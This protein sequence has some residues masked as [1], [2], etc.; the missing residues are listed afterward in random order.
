MPPE[1][2]HAT[3]PFEE[4]RRSLAIS[5]LPREAIVSIAIFLCLWQ[6]M[7][8]L[9]PTLGIPAFAIPGLGRIAMSLTK[10][11]PLDVVVTLARVLGALMLSF[12]IG[13]AVAICMYLSGSLGNICGRWCGC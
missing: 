4:P 6:A 7:S 11:T 8:Y 10:I 12:V 3:T 9:A 2:D 1:Q 5:S 13:L